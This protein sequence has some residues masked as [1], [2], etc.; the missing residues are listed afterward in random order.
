M[1]GAVVFG[2]IG[3]VVGWLLPAKWT[4]AEAPPTSSL[5]A[6]VQAS[7]EAAPDPVKQ[8]A[9]PRSDFQRVEDSLNEM[10]PIVGRVLGSVWN[11]EMRLLIAVG[12][13]PYLVRHAWL[14]FGMAVVLRRCSLWGSSSQ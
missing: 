6:S 5:L 10:I 14:L 1:S 13:M 11:L 7:I 8:T 9:A 2:P 3:F 12:L 4:D